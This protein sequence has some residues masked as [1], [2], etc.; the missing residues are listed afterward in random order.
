MW[1]PRNTCDAKGRVAILGAASEG[2]DKAIHALHALGCDIDAKN[3][4]G[5]R[6]IHFAASHGHETT[7]T[8]LAW[9]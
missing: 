2:F 1:Q 7:I 3:E 8:S 6:A 9:C 5:Q 4:D